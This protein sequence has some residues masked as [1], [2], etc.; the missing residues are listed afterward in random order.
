M[1][2]LMVT[3]PLP[4][5]SGHVAN[6]TYRLSKHEGAK[7]IIGVARSE[8]RLELARELGATHVINTANFASLAVDLAKAI[9]EIAPGRTN[10][11]FD[12]T[13]VIPIIDAGVHSLRPRGQMILI[14]IVDGQMS[15]DLD[16]MM[17]VRIE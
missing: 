14:G 5:I 16:P 15:L 4:S 2:A 1:S 7:I 17:T 8:S 3:R 10:A 6:I 9:N 12:T 11:N 13:G